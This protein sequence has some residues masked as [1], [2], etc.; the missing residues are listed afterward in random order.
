LLAKAGMYDVTWSEAAAASPRFQLVSADS[1]TTVSAQFRCHNG[2]T[3]FGIS[4]Y[5][6]GN[7]PELGSWDTE[8]AVRLAPDGPYPAWTGAVDNLPPNTAIEWKCIKRQE[9]GARQ[10]VQWESG[11]NNVFTTPAS[12]SA[13][14][15]KGEF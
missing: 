11:A 10:V 5:V 2:S 15:Q 3:M 12:G 13:G 6:V 7:V 14:E 9:S 1:P 4:V 8:K